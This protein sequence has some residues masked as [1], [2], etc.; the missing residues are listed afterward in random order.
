MK[1]LNEK[2]IKTESACPYCGARAGV[3]KDGACKKCYALIGNRVKR[4]EN[5]DSAR[6]RREI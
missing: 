1:G 5:G 2:V 4:D 6:N 3:T